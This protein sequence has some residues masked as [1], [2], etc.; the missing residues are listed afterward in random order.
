MKVVIEGIVVTVVTVVKAV[1]VENVVTVVKIVTSVTKW[2]LSVLINTFT[3]N[4]M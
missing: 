2:P 1:L 3:N 4:T